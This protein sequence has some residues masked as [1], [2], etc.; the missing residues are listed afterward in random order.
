MNNNEL[1][2]WWENGETRQQAYW[3]E[4]IPFDGLEISSIWGNMEMIHLDRVENSTILGTM[5][6]IHLDGVENSSRLGTTE[7]IHL[8]GG[9]ELK[10][11]GHYGDD[12]P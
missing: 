1:T 12:P 5:E 10:Y 7:M 3:A 8:D 11:M 9:G 4:M 2:A 6:M